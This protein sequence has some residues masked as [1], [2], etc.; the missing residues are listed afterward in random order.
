[1]SYNLHITAP[2]CPHC[3]APPPTWW[4]DPT[5]N[6]RTIF[7][8]AFGGNGIRDFDGKTAREILPTLE[9][10]VA[11]MKERPDHYRSLEPPSKWGSYDGIL[12]LL[13][14]MLVFCRE[15]PDA[16]VTV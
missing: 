13:C 5:Y 15:H 8:E 1:M 6:L 11:D 9:R 10:G 12:P 3:K 4:M 16:M 14:E 2:Q 7:V